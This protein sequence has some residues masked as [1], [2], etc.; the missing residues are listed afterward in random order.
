MD[1]PITLRDVD[2]LAG[3]LRDPRHC[4]YPAAQ[5]AALSEEGATREGLLSALNGLAALDEDATLFLFYAG[6]GAQ[7]TDGNYHLT[8]HDTKVQG[9]QIVAETGI[10]EQEFLERLRAVKTK[11]LLL[12][13]NACYSGELSPTLSTG[14]ELPPP[15]PLPERTAA[16]L[17]A[18]GSGRVIITACREG[19]VA[20]IG[21]GKLSLFAHA[22]V[23][24]LQGKG[25]FIA[26]RSGFISAFDLY[27][28][29]YDTLQTWVPLRVPDWAR[30]QHG[31]H[32]EPELT[33]LK[34]VGPFAVARYKGA[35]TLGTFSAPLR[36]ELDA[37][38]REVDP[39]RSERLL[40]RILQVQAGRDANSAGRD[41]ST[42]G[43]DNLTGAQ[44][45]GG[46]TG[47]DRVERRAIIDGGSNNQFGDLTFGD[48]AGGNIF[49]DNI[50]VGDITGSS[51][52]AIGRGAS[53]RVSTGGGG[54][55]LAAAFASIYQRLAAN[56]EN[57]AVKAIVTEQVQAV[58][59]ETAK[60]ELADAVRIEGA[61]TVIGRMMPAI[62]EAT[63]S[64]LLNPVAGV[65]SV[66]QQVAERARR[67]TAS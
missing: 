66:V 9:G 48:I 55:Q 14:D 5:V 33:V 37:G 50:S 38:L 63:I 28:H 11:R 15:T 64:A 36:P 35:T 46:Y 29:L 24:G 26:N 43:R 41:V 58:E 3:V 53:A 17:L 2:A 20:Y 32:Q 67:S 21:D 49:K 42:A 8:A 57:S 56:P 47:R 4:G 44:I 61:L 34:G 18:T 31:E 27:S 62:L 65:S 39:A 52:V 30:Q 23:D 16:A 1:I 7:G 13:V 59:A 54:N 22:L 40:S 19:Q 45:E 51:G 12:L 25:D 60:G 10:S 6:H